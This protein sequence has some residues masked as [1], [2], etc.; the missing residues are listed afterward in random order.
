[1]I[2]RDPLLRLDNTYSADLA[3]SK[4]DG[5]TTATPDGPVTYRTTASNAGPGI[6][7]AATVADTFRVPLSCT[8]TCLGAGGGACTASGCGNISTVAN[9]AV[10]GSVTFEN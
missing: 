8:W 10:A 2:R 9:I 4:S 3:I 1:M 5:V 6:V 7:P